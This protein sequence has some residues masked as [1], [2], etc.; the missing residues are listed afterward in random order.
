[1]AL[2]N[3]VQVQSPVKVGDI[4]VKDVLG[5]GAQLCRLP[6]ICNPYCIE[7]PSP[8]QA[9]RRGA[10]FILSKDMPARQTAPADL[11][12]TNEKAP[13]EKSPQ[14]LNSYAFVPAATA[15][16]MGSCPFMRPYV[17]HK[18]GMVFVKRIRHRF[19]MTV[20]Q[21]IGQIAGRFPSSRHGAHTANA[22]YNNILTGEL[23]RPHLYAPLHLFVGTAP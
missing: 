11:W 12:H 3:A 13:G 23:I 19:R 2:L 14:A 18:F 17:T 21:K 1:M 22:V 4:V 15:F 8:A 10:F 7:H 9:A 5:T 6:G 20:K 16:L